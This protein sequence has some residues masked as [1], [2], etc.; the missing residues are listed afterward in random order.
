MS[1]VQRLYTSD[2]LLMCLANFL[3]AVAFYF[4]VS[5]LPL[6]LINELKVPKGQ[7]GTIISVYTLSA[8]LIR[9]LTGYAI[10]AFS[11]K[12]LYLAAFFLFTITFGFYSVIFSFVPFLILRFL[13]GFAWGVTTTSGSTSIVDFIPEHRRGE[14]IG[15]YGMSFTIAM[16]I[17]PFLGLTIIHNF[18][19]SVMFWIATSISL[20]GFVTLLFIQFPPYHANHKPKLNFNK[21]FSRRAFPVSINLLIIN[22]TYGALI[23]YVTIYA[24]EKGFENPGFFFLIFA[25]GVAISRII[26]GKVFDMYGA[27][28]LG[29]VGTSLIIAGFI[30]LGLA[31]NYFQFLISA[32][33][34]GFG[35]GVI[36]PTF[37]TMVNNLVHRNMR[38][39]ANSTLFIFLDSGIGLGALIFGILIEYVKISDSYLMCSI[40]ALIG[41]IFFR[42]FTLKHY[43]TH[44]LTGV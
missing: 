7:V 30:V 33:I 32:I 11:R 31:E 24:S 3:M 42:L 14:G 13:H 18:D 20:I 35:F 16:A 17:G 38:G 28:T 1:R 27:S 15:I 12:L 37:S 44:K 39:A 8:I 36:S 10:D 6:Y 34:N 29:V 25:I 21:L 26:A 43:Q 4:L 23:T 9:P 41:L 2:F 40:I 19:Y 5:S 22:I